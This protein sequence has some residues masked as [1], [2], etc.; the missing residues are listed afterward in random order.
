MAIPTR[1]RPS[2]DVGPHLA[3]TTTRRLHAQPT[4]HQ[5][6]A[7]LDQIQYTRFQMTSSE[8]VH[9]GL[10]SKT[11]IGGAGGFHARRR[12]RMVVAATLTVVSVSTRR[13]P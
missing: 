3:I 10:D 11:V 4:E 13:S 8:V 1:G 2:Q 6:K 12:V 5:I 9:G 7:I